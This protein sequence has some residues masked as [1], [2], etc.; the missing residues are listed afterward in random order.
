MEL[1]LD[2][3][4]YWHSCCCSFLLRTLVA[5]LKHRCPPL[6]VLM[7]QIEAQRTGDGVKNK[8]NE[9]HHKKEPSVQ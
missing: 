9:P 3:I 8:P 6:A 1:E 5:C 4:S 7:N 2:V